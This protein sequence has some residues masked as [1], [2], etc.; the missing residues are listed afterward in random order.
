MCEVLSSSD[1]EHWRQAMQNE[2]N[3]LYE[4]FIKLHEFV[5]LTQDLDQHNEECWKRTF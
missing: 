1:F 5:G 4:Q 2:M 3:S